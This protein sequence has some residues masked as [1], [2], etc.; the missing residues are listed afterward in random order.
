M[1]SALQPMQRLIIYFFE[2]RLPFLAFLAFLAFLP[3]F[4]FLARKALNPAFIAMID[5][6]FLGYMMPPIILPP[7][8]IVRF[9]QIRIAAGEVRTTFIVHIIMISTAHRPSQGLRSHSILILLTAHLN[10]IP[11]DAPAAGTACSAETA[12]SSCAGSAA[13]QPSTPKEFCEI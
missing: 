1:I 2:R 8:G 6:R 7:L 3:A 5:L 10:N 11:D 9:E 13:D 4:F 12:A